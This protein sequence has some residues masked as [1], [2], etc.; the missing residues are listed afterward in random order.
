MVMVMVVRPS[1]PALV[2]VVWARGDFFWRGQMRGRGS[3]EID[4]A[5][6]FFP[7]HPYHDTRVEP[8]FLLRGSF[9]G[10]SLF[11]GGFFSC[12]RA[13]LRKDESWDIFL[14]GFLFRLHV[15]M[16]R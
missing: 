10:G 12:Y 6:Y 16:A 15:R 4:G 7:P 14:G 13:K 5:Y 8:F 1:G 3:F 11:R 2:C 9:G